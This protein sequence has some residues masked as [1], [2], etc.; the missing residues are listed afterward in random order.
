MTVWT[1]AE[2][3]RGNAVSIVSNTRLLRLI[4]SFNRHFREFRTVDGM[5]S[6]RPGGRHGSLLL[7]ALKPLSL[8]AKAGTETQAVL[9]KREPHVH[10]GVDHCL[11]GIGEPLAIGAGLITGQVCSSHG[12]GQLESVIGSGHERR[13]RWSDNL[14]DELGHGKRSWAYYAGR[15]RCG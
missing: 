13:T 4:G 7:R 14:S 6:R 11:S 12:M 3:L 5:G 8:F 2:D 10:S 9:T 1:A 15:R